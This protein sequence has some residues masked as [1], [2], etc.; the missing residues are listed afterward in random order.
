MRA[1]VTLLGLTLL[2]AGLGCRDDGPITVAPED[3]R[4]RRVFSGS[5]IVVQPLFAPG[6]DERLFLVEQRG[7]IRIVRDGQALTEPFLD[8]T[9]LVSPVS[10]QGRGLLSMAFHPDFQ[11]NG[12]FFVSYTV[13]NPDTDRTI[14]R[15]D[16]VRVS[17]EPDRADP[18]SRIRVFELRQS[19]G[20][21]NGGHIVFGPDRMLYVAFGDGGSGAARGEAQNRRNH[22][23]SILRIDVTGVSPYRVPDDNPFAGHPDVAPEVLIWGVRN[24]WRLSFDIATGDL[25]IADVGEERWEEV[26][27]VRARDL[28]R[29]D[30]NLGWPVLEGRECFE[31]QPCVPADFILPSF[32]YSHEEGCSIIGGL[33][34]RGTE[35]T[36]LVGRYLFADLCEA[37]VRTVP[38]SE[39]N[40]SAGELQVD[41]EGEHPLSFGANNAGEIY[42][43]T[44]EG[45]VFRLEAAGRLP[46][47]SR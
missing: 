39:V 4:A 10:D 37:W 43:S 25:W 9:A 44:F 24:P 28:L 38:A 15:I 8:L 36:G 14:S 3:V 35:L 22:L 29:E 40:G 32:V 19:L 34:Y 16:R 30:L 26:T 46:G 27:V 31:K 41:L 5:G 6:D 33:V 7:V 2:G 45:S 13:Q 11:S 18:D 23:G 21:H 1:P 47:E 20:D 17:P 42:L 12:E